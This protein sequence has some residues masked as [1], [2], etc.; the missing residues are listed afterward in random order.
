MCDVCDLKNICLLIWLLVLLNMYEK[1]V[2]FV[3]VFV[4][5]YLFVIIVVCRN[6]CCELF[7]FVFLYREKKIVFSVCMYV[8]FFYK[9]YFIL[10]VKSFYY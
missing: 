7:I 8:L 9:S 3:I 6:V 4:F 10:F 1:F 2:L 5:K